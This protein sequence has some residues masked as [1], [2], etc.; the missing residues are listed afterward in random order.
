[1]GICN[2][3]SLVKSIISLLYA[4]VVIVVIVLMNPTNDVIINV[5]PT[6]DGTVTQVTLGV[7]AKNGDTNMIATNT[8][9]TTLSPAFATVYRLSSATF[10]AALSRFARTA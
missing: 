2:K 5:N 6:N 10:T 8:N 3:K 4:E 9:G 1:M 7:Y